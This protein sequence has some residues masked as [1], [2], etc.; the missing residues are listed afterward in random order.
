MQQLQ[1]LSPF[2]ATECQWWHALAL[3]RAGVREPALHAAVKA[4][5]WLP[6]ADVRLRCCGCG[7]GLQSIG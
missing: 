2:H 4:P 1:Q 5:L 7:G 3:T 6:A